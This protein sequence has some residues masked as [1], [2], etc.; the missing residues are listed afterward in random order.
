[1]IVANYAAGFGAEFIG[2]GGGLGEKGKAWARGHDIKNVGIGVERVEAVGVDLE[3]GPEDARGF[4]K[5]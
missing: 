5:I 3:E 1:M 4:V 2:S